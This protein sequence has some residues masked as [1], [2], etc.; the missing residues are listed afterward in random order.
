VNDSDTTQLSTV[1]AP[2][3]VGDAWSSGGVVAGI[4][5]Q[6]DGL[7]LDLQFADNPTMVLRFRKRDDDRPAMQRTAKLDASHDGTGA[8]FD[9]GM[10]SF[11]KDVI[12]VVGGHEAAAIKLLDRPQRHGGTSL[13]KRGAA[14]Y[15]GGYGEQDDHDHDHDDAGPEQRGTPFSR[16]HLE[17]QIDARIAKHGKTYET[18][19]LILSNPCDMSCVFCPVGDLEIGARGGHYDDNAELQELRFQI[20]QNDRLGA[21]RLR[22]SGNDP[23]RHKLLPSVIE[24]A[25]AHGFKKVR[26]VTP[27]LEARKPEVAEMIGGFGVETIEMPFYGPNDEVFSGITGVPDSFA[28]ADAA[29]RNLLK[30]GVTPE[31]HGIAIEKFLVHLPATLAWIEKEYGLPF[32]VGP[33]VPHQIDLRHHHLMPPFAVLKK[34]I[35]RYPTVFSRDVGFPLCWFDDPLDAIPQ[36]RIRRSLS[37]Y[38]LSL[39][40]EELRGDDWKPPNEMNWPAATCDG[41]YLR[42]YPCPGAFPQYTEL[43]GL[44]GF[45]PISG[46]SFS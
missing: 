40:Y 39:P 21:T 27:G 43:H 19:E 25:W 33:Y 26:I 11:A 38:T 29:V 15:Q 12:D 32:R 2:R 22:V 24:A 31:L 30:N 37:L 7:R 34:W 36:E 35:D 9:A 20:S 46:D 23:L 18:V 1:I 16:V 17:K 14:S 45:A 41:C 42:G 4:C 10:N 8:D 5:R 6:G 44:D 28:K 13:E 3:A